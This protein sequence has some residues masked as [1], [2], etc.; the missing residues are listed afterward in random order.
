MPFAKRLVHELLFI[1]R[2]NAEVMA[3][4]FLT[5][6]ANFHRM[7]AYSHRPLYRNIAIGWVGPPRPAQART[8]PPE[9]PS[10]PQF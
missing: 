2:P 7:T 8:R 3:L 10:L 4:A 5:S 9:S 1:K 6:M